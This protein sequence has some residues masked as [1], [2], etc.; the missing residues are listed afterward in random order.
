[1]QGIFLSL[2]SLCLLTACIYGIC[3]DLLSGCK[4][5]CS[6]N[7]DCNVSTGYYCQEQLCQGLILCD[8]ERLHKVCHFYVNFSIG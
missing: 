5:T 3:V 4:K 2:I 6:T 7:G 1:M 8:L